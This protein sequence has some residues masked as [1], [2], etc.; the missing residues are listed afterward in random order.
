V[1]F[2]SRLQRL[3]RLLQS[4]LYE[5]TMKKTT[6]LKKLILDKEILIM[7]AAY[8]AVSARIIEQV[9]FKAVTL[10]GYGISASFLGKPDV[11]LL[12]LTEMATYTR[13]ITEAVD[14]PVFVD[15][16]TGHGNVT[17]VKRTVREFEKA[18]AAGL[19]IEDQIFPKR[20]G[21]TEG[22]QVIL[23]EEMMAKIKAAV[24]TRIDRDL[25]IMARTDAFATHGIDEAI[26]RGNRY[27][28][29][30]AD[31]IF[32][33]APTSKE[34]MVK[35]A[36]EVGAPTMAIQGEGGKTPLMTAR[37]LEQIGYSVV[38]YPGSALYAAA[39]AV[40]SVMGELMTTGTTNGFLD[41]MI[42]FSE[43]NQLIGLNEI[44]KMESHYY[45]GL[46]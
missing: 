36:R 26:A 25:I 4:K 40:R 42:T 8:D 45:R 17:N 33:E 9:G 34:D 2:I 14:I 18:G 28:E 37:E 32:V 30:G 46:L 31:L 27:R 6:T 15:G 7:P 3:I 19:F 21:H 29:A 13:N 22:K 38:V 43:F 1:E 41:K 44:K 11:S 24:D 35:I 20:C 12:T 23:A 39:W 5:E 16:D 10:G